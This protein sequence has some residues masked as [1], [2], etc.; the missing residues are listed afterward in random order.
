MDYWDE[1]QRVARVVEWRVERWVAETE[2]LAQMIYAIFIVA[3]LLYVA[4][5]VQGF[6]V[7]DLGFR[8]NARN[9]IQHST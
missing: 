2:D 8:Q 5:L 7:L 1:I 6:V 3:F 9:W 4:S